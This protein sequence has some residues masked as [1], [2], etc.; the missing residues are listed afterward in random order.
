MCEK[1]LLVMTCPPSVCSMLPEPSALFRRRRRRGPD[2]PDLDDR[3][4]VLRAVVVHL[5]SVVD[6]VAS[7]RRRNGLLR[8]ERFS[9]AHPPRPGEHDEEAVVRMEMRAAHVAGK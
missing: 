4:L 3:L 9:R 1:P 6:H 7:R 8:I 5:A 2:P